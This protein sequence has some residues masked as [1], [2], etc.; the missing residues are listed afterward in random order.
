MDYYV[1]EV[2]RVKHLVVQF[3]GLGPD[4]HRRTQSTLPPRK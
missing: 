2:R 3:A 1:A 4:S